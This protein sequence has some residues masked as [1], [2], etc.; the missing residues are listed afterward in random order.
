MP[1]DNDI[2][3]KWKTIYE[4]LLDPFTGTVQDK[5]FYP[6]L[7]SQFNHC[8]NNNIPLS[9]AI[10][11]IQTLPHTLTLKEYQ[12]I[13]NITN[14]I[15]KILSK[16]DLLFYNGEQTFLL[17]LPK[18]DKKSA[19]ELADGIAMDIAVKG[20]YAEFPTDAEDLF[21]L[22]ECAKKALA[23]AIQFNNNKIIGYFTERRKTNRAT[24]QIEIRYTA[25]GA[26]ERL[27]C[28]RNISETGIMLSGMPDLVLGEEIRLTLNLA[29]Q[30]IAI[31]AKT[32]W[33]RI[34][35]STGKMDIG[36]CFTSVNDTAK[37][38]IKRFISTIIPPVVKL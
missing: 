16:E 30:R 25:P 33:N 12:L 32:V 17:I 35:I 28:S 36:L 21:E 6:I 1:P 19:K 22:Q 31:L 2:F 26:S 13:T 38:V 10:L 4:E 20:G 24:L 14:L 8:K 15:R 27:T 29:L 11:N 23:T 5:Y 37:A 7:E 18:T 9:I 34:N 3:W